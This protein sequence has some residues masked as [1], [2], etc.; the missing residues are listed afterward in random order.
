MLLRLKAAQPKVLLRPPQSGYAEREYG[1]PGIPEAIPR[2]TCPTSLLPPCPSGILAHPREKRSIMPKYAPDTQEEE[3]EVAAR[4]EAA[5]LAAQ[6]LSA[7]Y[8]GGRYAAEANTGR[9][10]GEC[11]TELHKAIL[12]SLTLGGP[13]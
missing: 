10:M 3:A 13:T 2:L 8:D 7:A 5:D 11:F 1:H 4:K 12:N 9:G 6:I